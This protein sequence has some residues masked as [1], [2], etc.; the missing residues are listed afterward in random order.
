MKDFYFPKDKLLSDADLRAQP[1]D[2]GFSFVE[3]LTD[4]MLCELLK[5]ETSLY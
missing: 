3:T 5:Q 1:A 4:H 2:S